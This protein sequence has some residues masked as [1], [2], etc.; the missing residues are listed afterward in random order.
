MPLLGSEEERGNAGSV[1]RHAY[2]EARDLEGLCTPS[3]S[4]DPPW[5]VLI[6]FT[7]ARSLLVKTP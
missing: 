7:S 4:S 1:W 5:W 2:A 6:A 3:S